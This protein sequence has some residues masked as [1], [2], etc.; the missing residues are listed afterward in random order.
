ML[1]GRTALVLGRRDGQIVHLTRGDE[2][3]IVSVHRLSS[4]QVRLRLEATPDWHIQ[5]A[6]LLDEETKPAA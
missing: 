4:Q 2:T 3:I 1:N 6:E 5:R